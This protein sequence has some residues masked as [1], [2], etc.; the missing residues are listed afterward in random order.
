MLGFQFGE[1]QL[2]TI[3]YCGILVVCQTQNTASCQTPRSLEGQCPEDSSWWGS[4]TWRNITKIQAKQPI[5]MEMF[6]STVRW[7][8]NFNKKQTGSHIIILFLPKTI[9]MAKLSMNHPGGGWFSLQKH[10]WKMYDCWGKGEW[11]MHDFCQKQ[12][13]GSAQWEANRGS[14]QMVCRRWLV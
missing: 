8:L 9:W 3:Q 13:A 4:L 5:F 7:N 11:N 14:S 2:I 12:I 1:I 10:A 6:L